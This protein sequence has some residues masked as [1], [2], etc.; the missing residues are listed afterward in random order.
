MK[1]G[2]FGMVAGVGWSNAKGR[3][4]HAVELEGAAEQFDWWKLTAKFLMLGWRLV[5]G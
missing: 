1:I 3:R 2:V 5:P 4:V